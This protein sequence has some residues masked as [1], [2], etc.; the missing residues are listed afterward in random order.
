MVFDASN[1]KRIYIHHRP[2]IILIWI[3]FKNR[4]HSE[5]IAMIPDKVRMIEHI[6]VTFQNIDI[7]T[8][9]KKYIN[10]PI[11]SHSMPDFWNQNY[12]LWNL[13]CWK[14]QK[15]N[16]EPWLLLIALLFIFELDPLLTHN[17]TLTTQTTNTHTQKMEI[18]VVI[19]TILLLSKSPLFRIEWRCTE[20]E[21]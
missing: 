16:Q 19:Y 18:N 7:S 15:K 17:K 3:C 14:A 10:S 21:S 1:Q 13:Q 20:F 6:L 4:F 12:G 5:V 2:S 8:E 9:F 11:C